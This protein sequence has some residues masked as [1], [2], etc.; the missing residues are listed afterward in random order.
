MG[1]RRT[2]VGE[3]IRGV[4]ERRS[5]PP[6]LP[7]TYIQLNF[8]AFGNDGNGWIIATVIYPFKENIYSDFVAYE[9]QYIKIKWFNIQ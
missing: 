5:V 7:L 4:G 8:E 2:G 1:E 9:N 6:C 3:R